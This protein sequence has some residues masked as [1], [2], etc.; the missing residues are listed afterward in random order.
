[1]NRGAIRSRGMRSLTALAGPAMSALV[2]LVAAA[3]FLLG[4]STLSEHPTFASALALLALLQVTAVLINLLPV[5]GLDGFA[6]LE[7]FLS[8]RTLQRLGPVRQWGWLVLFVLLFW[9]PRGSE[10]FWD[11][12]GRALDALDVSRAA[13]VAGLRSFQFWVR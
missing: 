8:R 9:T 11:T 3:P 13:A 10:F 7:P 2:A 5:P 1:V 6:A 4:W 12:A